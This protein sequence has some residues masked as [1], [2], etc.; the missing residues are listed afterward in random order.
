[1][2]LPSGDRSSDSQVASDVVKVK[3][4]SVRSGSPLAL[5]ASAAA[6]S[7]CA[8]VCASGAWVIV[9]ANASRHN[10]RHANLDMETSWEIREAVII[11][12]DETSFT[13]TIT[14]FITG[15]PGDKEVFKF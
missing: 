12:L 9:K 11:R 4:L 10:R 3:S 6:L 1:M 8:F 5:I 2:V 14:V 13:P 15:G 7:F